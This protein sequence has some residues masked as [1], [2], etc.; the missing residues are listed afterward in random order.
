MRRVVDAQQL[1]AARFGRL[2]PLQEPGEA[3]DQQ[4]I[5]DC[6]QTFRRFRMPVR[7][8]VPRAQRMGDPG[9]GQ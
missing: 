3:A 7:D 6:G 8:A 5:L 4:A 2:V 9:D 1:F